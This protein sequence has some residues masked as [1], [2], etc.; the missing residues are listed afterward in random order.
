VLVREMRNLQGQPSGAPPTDQLGFF[1]MGNTNRPNGGILQRFPGLYIPDVDIRFDGS[2]PIDTPYATTDIGWEYDTASDFP[3]YPLNLLADLNAV[4]AGPITHSNY[5]NADV[6]GPRA[7]PDTTVGNITYITL[8]APH[9]PLL[10]PFYYAGFPKPL[11][12]LVEPAL[13]V[14]IDWAYDRSISPGTPTTARLIPNINPLTAIGDLAD[15]VAEGVRRFSADLQP[16]VPAVPTPAAARYLP[17]QH[18][19]ISAATQR[20]R[21]PANP[22][23]AATVQRSQSAAATQARRQTRAVR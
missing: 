18:P 7:F 14:M 4:F 9:L 12:D 3:L 10:L 2:T 6:N 21:T 23:R 15:A 11:L 17:R 20:Q 8:R 13:T 22:R 5:F 19:M 1:L 16:A